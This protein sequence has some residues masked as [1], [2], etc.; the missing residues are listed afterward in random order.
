MCFQDYKVRFAN[1]LYETFMKIFKKKYKVKEH[2]RTVEPSII[3]CHQ[4]RVSIFKTK[5]GGKFNKND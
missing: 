3:Q 2:I 1:L 4:L 5:L